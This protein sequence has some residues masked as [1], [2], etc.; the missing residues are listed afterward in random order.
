[1]LV[2][3]FP[4]REDGR[5]RYVRRQ[6]VRDPKGAVITPPSPKGVRTP[7]DLIWGHDLNDFFWIQ[8]IPGIDVIM[9]W[10]RSMIKELGENYHECEFEQPDS[11]Q[12]PRLRHPWPVLKLPRAI[13]AFEKML[14]CGLT[15]L[16]LI[17]EGCD[18]HADTLS[19]CGAI[20]KEPCGEKNGR[21]R[22]E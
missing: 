4:P 2:H 10:S 8:R 15:H 14:G 18:K 21:R 1:M 7:N 16:G 9:I 13:V 20:V 6:W 12:V 11:L 5:K 19:L 17:D 3:S 22:I